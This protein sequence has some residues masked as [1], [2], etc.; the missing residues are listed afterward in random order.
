MPT[1]N[2]TR[3]YSSHVYL[4][5]CIEENIVSAQQLHQKTAFIGNHLQFFLDNSIYHFTI[6]PSQG[7]YN[8]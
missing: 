8:E 1:F 3:V 5:E 6:S 7:I 4:P 2:Y